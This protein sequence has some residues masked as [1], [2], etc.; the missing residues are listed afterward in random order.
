M[1]EP[2]SVTVARRRWAL[3]AIRTLAVLMIVYGA[4]HI[5]RGMGA[6]VGLASTGSPFLDQ[7]IGVFYDDMYNPFWHGV[8]IALPGVALGWLSRRLAR[9]IVPV[10]VNE[11]PACGYALRSL[12]GPRC[13]ECGYP[14][15]GDGAASH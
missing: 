5:L 1:A 8:S 6:A 14:L 2:S 11:C 13:P 15:H 9:W 7:L 3:L 10:A 4:A 12:K